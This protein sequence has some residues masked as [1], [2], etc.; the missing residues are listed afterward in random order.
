MPKPGSHLVMVLPDLHIPHHDETALACV[1]AAYRILKPRRVVVLGD[2]LDCE[3]FSSH[4]TSSMAEL[5]AHRFVDDEL[6]PCRRVLDKLQKYNNEL[7]F[8]EGNHEQRIERWAA[9]WGQ[10]LGP[11]IYK[12]IAPRK[13]LG[14]GRKKFTWVPYKGHLSRYE[15]TPDLWAIHGWS[16]AKSAARVH[17]EK[18]VSVSVVHGHTHRQQMET[19]RDP[20]NGRI[21]KAWSPGCLCKLQPLYRANNPTAWVHGFSLIYIGRKSWTEYTITIK[22]GVCVLPD[23]REIS[24]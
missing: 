23:G 16:F 19:R 11:D 6:D 12:M 4:G 10:R 15:I 7:V 22:D 21:L 17:Q 9:Q 3:Q 14:D 24:G 1:M 2:W 18:A 20:A 5:R 13:L 8:I